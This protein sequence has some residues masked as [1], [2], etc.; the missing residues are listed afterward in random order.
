MNKKITAPLALTLALASLPVAHAQTP[1]TLTYWLWEA[2]QLP[3]YQQ[4][5]AGFTKANPDINVK[6]EQLAWGS[7][8]TS[9]QTRMVAGNAPDV[10]TDHLAKYPT[11]AAN[12]QL[13]DIA[14]LVARDKVPTNIYYTGLADL[15]THGKARYG[16]PK[17]FDTITM[18]YNKNMVKAAGISEAS[19]NA[20]T[21]NTDNGGSFAQAIAKLSLDKSGNN[22]L[23]AKFD[24]SSVKQYG[25]LANYTEGSDPYGQNSW[26]ALATSTGWA[27]NNGLWGNKYNYDDPRFMKTM[28][29]YADLSLKQGFAP[30]YASVPT[31]GAETL[32]SSGK[33]AL[34]FAGSWQTSGVLKNASFPVGIALLPTGPQGRRSMFNGL[35]DSIWAG[36]KNKD[37]AWKWVKYL[38][39]PAC[40]NVI[41]AQG[42]VFPA[43]K[44]GATKSESVQ[45]ARGTNVSAFLKEANTKGATFLFPITENAP[46]IANLMTPALQSIFTGQAKAADVLPGV[47]TQINA[48]FR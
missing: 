32:F 4:C 41:G 47:N 5:A 18:F 24:K 3:G 26:S 36:S 17:D 14:S 30:P 48:L 11:F 19:L 2:A 37:Q 28:Q 16:L 38:A 10:F 43:I 33:V 15:W 46:Q 31:S 6:I 44:S 21:W 39:S 29:W 34:D 7:Y 12:N 20:L 23:S 25:F 27:F 1:T 40:Q 45:N 35:A 42:V 8:W 13:V 9:L 22:G